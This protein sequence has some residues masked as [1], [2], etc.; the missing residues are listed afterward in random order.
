M[1]GFNSTTRVWARSRPTD[2]RLGFAGL[3]GLVQREMGAD[4]LSGDLFLFLSRRRNAVRVL[5][6]DG[7]GLC[8]YSKRLADRRF[9]AVWER[10]E[11]GSIRLTV[12]ELALFLEGSTV[13]HPRREKIK[14]IK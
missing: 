11:G 14:L 7:T 4:L 10:I 13:T 8:L 12:A 5:Q 1:M 9:A 2:L 3:A 6:W